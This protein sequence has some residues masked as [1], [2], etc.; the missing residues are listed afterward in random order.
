MLPLDDHI[1]DG[2]M[3]NHYKQDKNNLEVIPQKDTL[4]ILR[5]IHMMSQQTKV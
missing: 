5:I 4:F 3:V 1:W 2:G